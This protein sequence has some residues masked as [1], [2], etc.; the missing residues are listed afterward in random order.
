MTPNNA[1]E[2]SFGEVPIGVYTVEE[3]YVPVGFQKMANFE[4]KVTEADAATSL[5]F[6]VNDSTEPY[7]V[8][9]KLNDFLLRVEKVDP[10]GK[11]LEGAVFKLTGPNYEETLSGGPEFTFTKLR[12][13]SYS[14]K[15]IENPNGY[16]RIQEPIIFEIALDGKV[17]ITPHEDVA[18][19]GGVTE[20]ENRIVLKV[21][22]KKVR[23]GV[24]PSTG[25]MG[26]RAFQW[27]AGMLVMGG[28]LLMGFSLYL[29]RRKK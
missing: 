4:L 29:N 17:T 25:G 13:G 21:T 6:K 14:L 8:V 1:G 16:Q 12:P 5:V 20:E 11:L 27:A 15:E 19:I 2:V 18:G 26:I 23:A 10:Q 24:L 22:N 9:N 28:F 7:S 3:T